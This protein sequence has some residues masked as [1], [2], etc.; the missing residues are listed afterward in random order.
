MSYPAPNVLNYM[1]GKGTFYFDRFDADGN[2]TGELHLGNGPSFAETP[3]MENLDHFS[4][5]EG[6]KM[7]DLSV[8]TQA[9]IT[10]KFTLDEINVENLNL[11][12][13]GDGV[14]YFT[15][16]AGNQVNEPITARVGRFIKL[17][18]RSFAAGSVNVTNVA[19]TIT[20]VEGVDY[21]VDYLSG[22][23]FIIIGGTIADNQVLHV[24]YTYNAANIPIVNPITNTEMIGLVRFKG[25]CVHGAH[26]EIVHW[27]VK[28]NIEGDIN[29]IGDEWA[30]IAFNAEVLA[31]NE[32]HPDEPYGQIF[33]LLSDTAPES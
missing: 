13:L 18:R 22:R 8:I 24:D 14:E 33:D 26:Y 21:E 20:Y 17:S 30:T 10:L 31:D 4:S 23:I 32:K 12:F 15:Q 3:T 9:G 7:K 29:F 19:G 6:L 2:S 25:N 28:L 16:D 1:I 27:R 5:M 11:A